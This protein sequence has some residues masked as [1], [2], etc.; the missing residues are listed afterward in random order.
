MALASVPPMSGAVSVPGKVDFLRSIRRWGATQLWESGPLGMLRK[1][2][3]EQRFALASGKVR[4]FRG[5]YANYEEALASAPR[6]RVTETDNAPFADRLEHERRQVFAS[7]YPAVLWLS[8]LLAQNPFVFDL[9]GNVGTSY[10]AF[11]RLMDY[12]QDL[13]WLVQDV[14]AV[15]ARGRSLATAEPAPGLRFTID[16]SELAAADILL[17]KGAVHFLKDPMRFLRDCGPLPRHILINKIPLYDRETAVTLEG[18]GVTFVPYHL[19]NRREF[20]EAFEARGYRCVDS[21]RNYD[22][23]CYVP[24]HPERN[25][26]F[27][28]GV[29]YVRG[30]DEQPRGL[31]P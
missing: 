23:N 25:I 18:N 12:P 21:W 28:S 29:Y 10:F 2:R 17:M 16:C 20:N 15:V 24:F 4:M 9:G 7:D 11:R 5:I 30:A 27:Y 1:A 8:R 6:T 19:L 3:Y 13:T 22:L 31:H 26:P 14:P